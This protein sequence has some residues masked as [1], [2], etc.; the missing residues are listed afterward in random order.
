MTIDIDK[1]PL[2]V[3][4]ANHLLFKDNKEIL[5][6]ANTNQKL[7]KLLITVSVLVV[8]VIISN[9][10]IKKENERREKN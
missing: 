4:P 7:K 2:I 10:I 5:E 8:G 9:Q 3:L 1:L 6:I